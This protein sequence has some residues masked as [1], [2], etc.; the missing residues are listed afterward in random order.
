VVDSLDEAIAATR[1]VTSLDRRRCRTVFER[2]FGAARMAADYLHLYEKVVAR[3]HADA[4][5]T[6]GAA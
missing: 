5:R 2:R 1:R 6:P 3:H 4:R